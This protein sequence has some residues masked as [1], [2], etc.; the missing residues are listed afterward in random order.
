MIDS[1]FYNEEVSMTLEKNMNLAESLKNMRAARNLSIAE[2]S[3]ELYIP[4]STLQSILAE[5]QTSLHTAIHISEKLSIPLD[6]L[7]GG[8]MTQEQFRVH[9]SLLSLLDWYSKLTKEQQ[10]AACNNMDVLFKLI[11]ESS[12]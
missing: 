11:R 10:V 9:S 2:F 8:Q 6:V 7:T 3:R 4:K 12:G 5:G 1:I